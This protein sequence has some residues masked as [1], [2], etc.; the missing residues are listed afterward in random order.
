M[1]GSN[2]LAINLPCVRTAGG[3]KRV[4]GTLD[5]RRKKRESLREDCSAGPQRCAPRRQGWSPSAVAK[6]LVGQKRHGARQSGATAR[7]EEEKGH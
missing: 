7:R 6:Q 3:R 5:I 1:S 2:F 4:K